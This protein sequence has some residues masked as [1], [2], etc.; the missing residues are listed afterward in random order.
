MLPHCVPAWAHAGA[1][2]GISTSS[3][4]NPTSFAPLGSGQ[5]RLEK[6][7][8]R[9]DVH[10]G[11]PVARV[12]DLHDHGL[13]DALPLLPHSQL[14]DI[15]TDDFRAVERQPSI[16]AALN[17]EPAG[18]GNGVQGGSGASNRFLVRPATKLRL[19]LLGGFL[20]TVPDALSGLS[21]SR[22]GGEFDPFGKA[23]FS[24]LRRQRDDDAITAAGLEFLQFLSRRRFDSPVDILPRKL[25]N[26]Q[27]ECLPSLGVDPRHGRS[28]RLRRGF[29]G[30]DG[31][32]DG[33][34]G[35]DQPA[36]HRGGDPQHDVAVVGV[37]G[38]QVYV[39]RERTQL[40]QFL[41]RGLGEGQLDFRLPTRRNRLIR[42]LGYG[43]GTLAWP[44]G[45]PQGACPSLL[46]R[47]VCANSLPDSIV[48][49]SQIK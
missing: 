10:S 22:F 20:Q 27:F 7:R 21:G 49:K 19:R 38:E 3:R 43:A 14:Q 9:F 17:L 4:Y 32:R 46:T 23:A 13:E 26:R 28:L 39:P 24:H 16:H 42:Q 36:V 30:V 25:G 33:R 11:E 47:K 41:F 37:V 48:P 12:V 44:A 29:R 34:G 5:P 31:Q 8:L 1:S 15:A 45:E 35:N 18:G 6:C 2:P 40:K